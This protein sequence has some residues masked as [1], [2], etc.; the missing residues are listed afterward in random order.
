MRLSSYFISWRT[1][2][3]AC[4]DVYFCVF[5]H[6]AIGSDGLCCQSREMKEWHGCRATRGLLK[7]IWSALWPLKGW[8]VGMWIFHRHFKAEIWQSSWYRKTHSSSV[9]YKCNWK[10]VGKWLISMQFVLISW[11]FTLTGKHYYEVSCHDQGLCRVGWST[12]QAS[13][14]L[15][16]CFCNN[17]AVLYLYYFNIL[18]F[19]ET[20]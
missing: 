18:F 6:L 5:A 20:D 3:V 17:W 1:V 12:M 8:T 4:T 11:N 7:G 14:D 19:W 16:K 13:L 2:C 15:G 9:T 10:A